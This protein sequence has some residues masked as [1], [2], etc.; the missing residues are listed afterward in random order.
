MGVFAAEAAKRHTVLPTSEKWSE[1][2]LPVA[3][4]ADDCRNPFEVDY[5]RVIHSASFR[6]LQGKTQIL[7]SN[8]GDFHR[9]RMTHS[10]EVAQVAVG[11]L[12]HLEATD[13]REDVARALP[14][15]KLIE[16]ISLLHD[17]GHPPGGHGGEV[18]LC[19]CMRN[20]GGFEGNGQTLRILSKLEIFTEEHGSNM[21]RRTLLGILKYPIAFSDAVDGPIPDGKPSPI[22]GQILLSQHDHEPPKC[23]MDTERD[24]VDWIFQPLSADDRALVQSTRAKSFDCTIMDLADDLSYGIHDLEDAIALGLVSIEQMMEDIEPHLWSDFV[25]RMEEKNP[26]EYQDTTGTRYEGVLQALFS[27][28]PHTTK[29]VISRLVSYMLSN[30]YVAER[31]DFASHMYRFKATMQP[32]AHRLLEGLKRFILNR[33]IRSPQVQQIRF[34]TQNMIVQLFAYLDHDP[35]HLL[36]AHIYA[37]YRAVGNPSSKRRVICDYIASMTD[38]SLTQA[39]ER[40]FSPRV[41]SSFDSL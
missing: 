26:T 22:N 3:Q 31:P 23:Y 7:T 15:P 39:Y 27:G 16:A 2:M 6:R 38:A 41:G 33:V 13:R 21:T 24:V 5:S 20:D 30:T 9:T 18:S 17:L 10:L 37:K 25:R 8:D 14:H 29:K 12:K 4:S 28:D 40:L 1:R 35:R 11:I 34:K 32:E 36:P 19:Y